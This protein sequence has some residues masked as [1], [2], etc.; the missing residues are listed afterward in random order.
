MYL[1][2]Y[3]LIET[4]IKFSLNQYKEFYVIYLNLWNTQYAKRFPFSI[5]HNIE[6]IDASIL[7]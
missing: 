3:I 6:V 7:K 2:L 1:R 5:I 4:K